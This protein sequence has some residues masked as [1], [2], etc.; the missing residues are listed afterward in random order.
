M[1]GAQLRSVTPA[2]SQLPRNRTASTST[3]CTSSRSS[4]IGDSLA[5]ICCFSSITSSARIRPMSRIVVMAPSEYLSIFRVT[6]VLASRI[7]Q[8]SNTNAI[9]N[10]LE[11]L[12]FGFWRRAE[13]SASRRTF[14]ITSPGSPP[15]RIEPVHRSRQSEKLPTLAEIRQ[16]CYSELLM[17]NRFM[18]M[19]VRRRRMG[20]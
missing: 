11:S 13:I 19:R 8:T 18:T 10:L 17:R 7:C 16:E 15:H 20:S 3:N 9:R 1:Y 14:S 4:T 5:V 6:F 12:I 2:T